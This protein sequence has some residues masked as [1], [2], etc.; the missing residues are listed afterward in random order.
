MRPY[1][2]AQDR[3]KRD[4]RAEIID[5]IKAVALKY[6]HF[7]PG[8]PL[9]KLM[10]D[11]LQ[12]RN[13]MQ[14]FGSSLPQQSLCANEFL[15]ALA[16]EYKDCKDKESTKQV[17]GNAK[18]QKQKL[19]IGNTKAES[20]IAMF[21]ET[22]LDVS[23]RVEAAKKVG[24]IRHY[25]DEKRHLLSIVASDYPYRFLQNLFQCSPNTVTAARV[26]SILF[27]RGGAPAETL[28]LEGRE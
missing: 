22:P 17:K 12:S 21:G 18:L 27:G 6:V 1:Q 15:Q 11:I 3:T 19:L 4:V 2:E 16:K 26:H 8:P 28:N 24:R 23:S 13:W 20:K 14:V 10:E 7:E 25:G 5:S 9:V